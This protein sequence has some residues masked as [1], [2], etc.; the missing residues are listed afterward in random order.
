MKILLFILY[1]IFVVPTIYFGF[2]IGQFFNKK[3]REGVKGRKSQWQQIKKA[4]SQVDTNRKRVLFHCASVG[5]WEQVVPIIESIKKINPDIYTIVSFFSPSGYNYAKCHLYVDLKIYLPIDSYFAAKKLF[6]LIKPCLWVISKYDIWA[7]HIFTA[8]ALKI[9][10]INISATLSPN[11]GRDKGIT[12]SFNKYVYPIFDYIFPISISDMNRFLKIFPHPD[13][14][15]IS[16]DT[17]FDQ[18]YNKAMKAHN[19]EPIK[20][21]VD[22]SGLIFIGGSI[23]PS[24][25]KHLLP[26]LIAVMKKY[27]H[28]KAIL[29]PHELYEK[30]I[31]DIEKTMKNGGFLSERYSDF[32]TKGGTTKRVAI[33]NTI[34]ILS[35]L[36]KQTHIAYIGGSFS[37]GVH[38][39]I[40]PAIFGQP[41]LFGPCYTNS[42]EAQELK[43]RSCAFEIKTANEGEAIMEKLI[44]DDIFR[45]EIGKKAIDFIE[46][47]IGATKKIMDII[48][49]RYDFIS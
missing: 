11:S 37:T 34:G 9:P 17:R 36:Y 13:R 18:V 20:I 33:I 43:V 8:G 1:N 49:N 27:S 26:A 32:L 29:V 35:Q 41:I 25:E 31:T 38:N 22:C 21:F 48:S 15:T 39:V 44:I 42:F 24:D 23:W 7:N 3:I 30:H 14:M 5:E 40:E 12:K 2:Y 10:I 46:N 6:I 4:L 28:L 45:D 47:N 16:G 19:V